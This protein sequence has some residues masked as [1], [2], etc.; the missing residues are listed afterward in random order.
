MENPLNATVSIRMNHVMR[1]KAPSGFPQP[2]IEWLKDGKTLQEK[3]RAI[4]VKSNGNESQIQFTLITWES[5][6]VYQCVAKNS[7]TKR[8]SQ[9]AYIT[10][11][12]QYFE[13][14]I[15]YELY[16]YF[17]SIKKKHFI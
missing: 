4:E 7:E 15:L 11:N 1:C 17:I 16:K 3:P 12:G 2:T 5:R 14:S 8:V 13:I 6:G 9:S 10:V